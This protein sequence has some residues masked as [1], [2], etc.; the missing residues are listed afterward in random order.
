MKGGYRV[1]HSL[2][3]FGDWLPFQVDRDDPVG[4]IARDLLEDPYAPRDAETLQEIEDYLRRLHAS[5]QALA[6]L[7]D[8]WAEWSA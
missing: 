1:S 4:D 2:M 8:A 6:A 3:R 7:R 5:R